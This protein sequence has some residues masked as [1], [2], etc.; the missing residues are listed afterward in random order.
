[1]I[2]IR[3]TIWDYDVGLCVVHIK[4]YIFFLGPFIVHVVAQS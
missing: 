1:M 4:T 2:L 3:D